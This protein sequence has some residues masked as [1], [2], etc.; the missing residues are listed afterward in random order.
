MRIS[1]KRQRLVL[2]RMIELLEPSYGWTKNVWNRPEARAKNGLGKSFCLLGAADQAFMDVTGRKAGQVERVLKEMSVVTL[3]KAK[4]GHGSV[5]SFNDAK[6]TKKADV[7]DIL[8]EKRA[9][10][11]G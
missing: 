4:S 11:A 1:L 10:L 6:T 8:R 5:I 3:I 9:E 2:D 7:L